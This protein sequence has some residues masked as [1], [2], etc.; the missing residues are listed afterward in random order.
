MERYSRNITAL[1]RAENESLGEKSICIIGCGGLGEYVLEMLGRLGIGQITI[2]DGDNFE[3]S[4][5]NRQIYSDTLSLRRGKVEKARE[6]MLE[7][8]PLIN[9]KALH[10]QLDKNNARD[11]LAG[12]DVIVDALDN[13]ETRLNVQDNA[14]QLGI[15]VVHGAIGGWYGQVATIFPGDRLL[16]IIYANKDS[17]GIEKEMGNPSFIPAL[18]AS[19]QV[20]EAVKILIGRGE[21]LRNKLLH[22][23]LLEQEY[24]IL[25]LLHEDS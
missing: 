13:I 18:I 6:R 20:S 19:I 24:E 25:P 15:P 7:V 2:V 12:H 22:I 4:N 14:E 11:I 23:D 8:N 3:E 16:D 1:S 5:L 21:L 9:V 17:E 10:I